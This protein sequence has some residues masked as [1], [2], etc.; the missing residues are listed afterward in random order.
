MVYILKGKVSSLRLMAIIWTAS[1]DA[2]RQA[3][4]KAAARWPGGN[5]QAVTVRRIVGARCRGDGLLV[6]GSKSF[7]SFESAPLGRLQGFRLLVFRL[8]GFHLSQSQ[9]RTGGFVPGR[10]LITYFIKKI[11]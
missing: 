5:A 6:V 7:V 3:C 9:S 8:L 10:R 11:K 2:G 4:G 1:S